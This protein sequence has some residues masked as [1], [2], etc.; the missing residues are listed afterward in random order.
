MS[1]SDIALR[2]K[3]AF[4]RLSST[5][6]DS[7]NGFIRRVR[8]NLIEKREVILS[9]NALDLEEA[10]LSVA[11]GDLS[12]SLFSRLDLS[13]SKFDSVLSGLKSLEGLP[14]PLGSI[15]YSQQMAEGL[16]LYRLTCA[17]G[18][19]AVIFESRPEA[20]IQIASLCLKSG[21]AVILKGGR[22][23]TRSNKALIDCIRSALPDELVDAVQGVE[24]REAIGQLLGMDKL[25]DLIIPRGSAD[26]VRHIKKNT[27]IP[28]LGHADGICHTYVHEN[29]DIHKALAILIDA[30]TQYPAVCNATEVLLVDEQ[31]AGTF[32]PLAAEALVQKGVTLKL[33]DR[34]YDII[35]IESPL[36]MK[37]VHSDFDTE[38]CDLT[39]SIGVV[40]SIEIAIEH[41]NKHGSHHTDAIVTENQRAADVFM[42]KVESA[43]VYWNA[44]TRFADG[45]RY[46]FGAEVGVSTGKLH[47]RGPMGLEGLI[48]YKYRLYGDGHTLADYGKQLEANHVPV[49]SDHINKVHMK[50]YS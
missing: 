21:N 35:G 10:K 15:T 44:S 32:L 41:I 14:D 50:L 18:V 5:D 49:T 34:A 7:R 28:V 38:W 45:F 30:K 4:Q 40:Q 13:G 29:A 36:I 47:A 2:A 11:S 25:V 9:D 31:L 26:L 6:G 12:S 37:A 22:E 3:Q 1:V 43:G 20:A 39:L 46:G 8:E 27:L 24:S 17:I 23:A 48:T 16:S 19:V 42:T 33:D